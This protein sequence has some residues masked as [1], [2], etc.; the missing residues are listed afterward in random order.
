MGG[1]GAGHVG[2]LGADRMAHGGHERFG[3]GRHRFVGGDY[4]LSCPYY[5]YYTYNY[6]YYCDY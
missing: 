2:G 3:A 1:L 5:P 6:P 4:G